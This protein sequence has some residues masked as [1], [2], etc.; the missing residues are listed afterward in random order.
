M[1]KLIYYIGSQTGPAYTL[2]ICSPEKPLSTHFLIP[3]RARSPLSNADRSY[4]EAKGVLTLPKAKSCESLLRAYLHHVHP[5]MPVIEVDHILEYQHNGRLHEYNI[6]LLW[7]IF[8][9][10]VNVNAL[11]CPSAHDIMQY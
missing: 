4:L 7:S 3:S 6:L 2:D 1:T 5:I 11:W 8:S 9:A 10:A